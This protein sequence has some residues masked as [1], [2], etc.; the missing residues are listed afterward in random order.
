MCFLVEQTNFLNHTNT[1]ANLFTIIPH[2]DNPILGISILV[3]PRWRAHQSITYTQ[4]SCFA[5]TGIDK[6]KSPFVHNHFRI[7]D[8]ENEY[9]MSLWTIC[10]RTYKSFS[11][12]IHMFCLRWIRINYKKFLLCAQ[13]NKAAWYDERYAWQRRDMMCRQWKYTAH[14]INATDDIDVLACAVTG[15][16][17]V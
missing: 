17:K 10:I 5:W 3:A 14:N 8:N 6:K 2:A 16:L 13:N 11:D 12:L 9:N 15:K 4:N 7:L 1:C